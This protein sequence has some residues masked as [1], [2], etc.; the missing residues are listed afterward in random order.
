MIRRPPVPTRTD[1]L[2]P[3]TTLFR[4]P[5]RQAR[6]P[7]RQPRARGRDAVLALLRAAGV[8][9]VRLFEAGRCRARSRRRRA[10]AA[11]GGDPFRAAARPPVPRRAAA[12]WHRR[13]PACAHGAPHRLRWLVVVGADARAGRTVRTA[14][15]RADRAAA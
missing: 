4:S 11:C 7:A 15:G 12:P 13:P 2:F 9:D 5:A 14:A 8:A 10:P 3:Y 1:T 6:R